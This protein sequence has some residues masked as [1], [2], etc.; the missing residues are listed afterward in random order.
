MSKAF[1]SINRKLLLQDLTKI[2]NEDELHII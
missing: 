2:I 1:E